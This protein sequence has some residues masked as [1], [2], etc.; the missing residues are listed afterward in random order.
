MDIIFTLFILI[1]KMFFLMLV[2]VF[3][4]KK[5]L[6]S[7]SFTKDISSLLMKVAFP[8]IILNSFFIPYDDTIINN[9][10]IVVGLYL[11]LYVITYIV[12]LPFY[13]KS[14]GISKFAILFGNMGFMGIPLIS[15]I[16]GPEYIIYISAILSLFTI[17][18]WTH[19]LYCLTL[20][21]HD[22][23]LKKILTNPN[24]IAVLIGLIV[25]FARIEVPLIIQ[26]TVNYLVALNTPLAMIVVG[27][28][29]VKQDLKSLFNDLTVY[30]AS[31]FKLIILPIICA[32]ILA[33]IPGID[34]NL[35]IVLVIA[36]AT[37]SASSAAMF[38]ELYDKDAEYAS[39]I[40]S[41]STL[42]C[43]VTMPFIIFVFNLF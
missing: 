42:F 36:M 10:G 3:L 31:L 19:G 28:F 22:V 6:V 11:I 2:G 25:L 5:K 16:L 38:C 9:M 39:K 13:K 15:G 18:T 29:I 33:L 32:I 35:K 17:L 4:Y 20:N 24:T 30:K 14:D 40:V 21:K 26:D 7:E 23:T 41:V 1:L 27:I 37:P 8:L 34:V 43:I 12:I